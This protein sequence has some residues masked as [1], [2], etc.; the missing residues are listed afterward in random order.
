MI[1]TLFKTKEF[2]MS[3]YQEYKQSCLANEESVHSIENPYIKMNKLNS[4]NGFPS[5]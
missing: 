1:D 3:R 5:K 2:F 4:T